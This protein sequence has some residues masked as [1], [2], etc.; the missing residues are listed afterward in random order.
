MTTSRQAVARAPGPS[1][2]T[3]REATGRT[4]AQRIR[5]QLAELT[6]GEQQVARALLGDYPLLALQPVAVLAERAGTSAPT[7]LRLV[8]KLGLSG[9]PEL[10]RLITDELAARLSSPLTLY[11]TEP[12]GP[13]VFGAMRDSLVESV[14]HSLDLLD[15]ADVA[16]TV[17]LLADGDRPL[18]TV[19]G[20]FSSMLA[21]Y[22]A[23]HLM[24]LRGK[25]QHVSASPGRRSLAVLDIGADDVVVAFDYRRYQRS[26]ITFGEQVVERGATLV[27]FTDQLLSPLS[28]RATLVLPSTV[29][30]PTPFD[31]FTPALAVLESL[32]AAVVDRLGDGPRGRLSHFDSHDPDVLDSDHGSRWP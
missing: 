31:L 21:D 26:T 8:G 2:A 32:V 24:M 9:Y 23:L 28:T 19:G 13:E 4:V 3:P 29:D 17:E 27:L 1:A 20:R 6:P 12:A 15:P 18:W 30:G 5:A 7:V 22:L 10:Q 25:V 11:P 16:S 14:R